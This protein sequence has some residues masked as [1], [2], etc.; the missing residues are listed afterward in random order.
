MESM[1]DDPRRLRSL[2]EKATELASEHAVPSVLVGLKA[3]EGELCFPEFIDFLQAR[4]R[5]EDGI[6]RMTRERVVLHLA[7]VDRGQTEEILHRLIAE[8]NDQ[9]PSMT[10]AEFDVR[11]V[12]VKPGL[13]ELSVKDVLKDLFT[14]PRYH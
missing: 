6:F 10:D 5:V 3:E 12:E 8:F 9:Y 1:N 7:D 14:P 11:C 13:A 4:L 2:I